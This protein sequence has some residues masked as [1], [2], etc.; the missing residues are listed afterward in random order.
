MS[1]QWD[2]EVAELQKAYDEE[3][4]A[5]HRRLVR[6]MSEALAQSGALAVGGG[7]LPVSGA[8]ALEKRWLSRAANF[9]K[10]AK[11]NPDEIKAVLQCECARCFEACA[12]DLGEL[13]RQMALPTSRQP[14][15]NTKFRNGE[16]SAPLAK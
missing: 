9:R 1:E 7:S 6:A 2:K 10:T 12:E 13:R 16:D 8:E 15:E 14:E 3:S 5:Q 11:E 4:E